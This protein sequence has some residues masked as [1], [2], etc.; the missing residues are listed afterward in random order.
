MTMNGSAFLSATLITY[1]L[2]FRPNLPIDK[3]WV[4]GAL[5]II[6]L[7]VLLVAK[8]NLS[9][10]LLPARFDKDALL[11]GAWLFYVAPLRFFVGW[12]ALGWVTL[13][14]LENTSFIFC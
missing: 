7:A 1:L 5:I 13:F 3:K 10:N 11:R 9:R 8:W 14:G 4:G 12:V 6:A 2:L